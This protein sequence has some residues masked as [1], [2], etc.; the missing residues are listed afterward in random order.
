MY[1]RQ[2]STQERLI[3][4][5]AAYAAIEANLEAIGAKKVAADYGCLLYTSRCV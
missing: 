3:D 1:K 4:A 5:N 2:A